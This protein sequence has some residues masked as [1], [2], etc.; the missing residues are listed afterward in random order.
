V[1]CRDQRDQP[2]LDLAQAAKAHVL[3]SGDSDLLVLAGKT[4]FAIETPEVYRQRVLQDP[5]PFGS[6]IL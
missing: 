2:F 1:K 6:S 4:S 3:V 5:S